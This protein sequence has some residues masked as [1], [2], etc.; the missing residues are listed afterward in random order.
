MLLQFSNYLY[1]NYFHVSVVLLILTRA[2][3]LG[4]P[5]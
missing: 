4:N 2:N 3:S 1:S 5:R